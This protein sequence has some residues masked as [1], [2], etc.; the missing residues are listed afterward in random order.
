MFSAASI[1]LAALVAHR[2][3][4]RRGAWAGAGVLAWAVVLDGTPFLGAD[5]GGALTLVPAAAVTASMLFGWRIRLRS[6][7]MWGVAAVAAVVA[8]GLVDLMRPAP[9]R[10]HLGRLLADIGANGFEAL[11]TVVLRKL[12]AN[13]SVLMRSVWTLMLPVVFASVALVF[14][15]SPGR[16]RTIQERIPEERAA[17]AG[18]L[19]AMVLGFALNDSG[20]AVPGMM[21]GVVS[22]SLIHL[23]FRVEVPV[24]EATSV[25]RSAP[26]R[27]DAQAGEGGGSTGPGERGDQASGSQVA[28]T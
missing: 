9:E 23:M 13:L 26:S 2:L 19:T 27:Q 3:G 16:L 15:R 12:D 28:R 8:L 14:W 10:T 11:Q 5:V 24:S 6:A 17:V 20:I 4:G 21:L 1:I 25:E 7:V 22:A 18:L